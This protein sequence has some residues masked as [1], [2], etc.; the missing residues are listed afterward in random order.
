MGQA[1]GEL[2]FLFAERS[3]THWQAFSFSFFFFLKQHIITIKKIDL[4]QAM[5][6]ELLT[7]PEDMGTAGIDNLQQSA[8]LL[9]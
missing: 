6:A 1:G 8:S 4:Q 7:C 3:R 5:S 2:G 9:Q